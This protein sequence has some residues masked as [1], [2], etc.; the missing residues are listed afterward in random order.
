LVADDDHLVAAPGDSG[1]DVIDARA[2]CQAIVRLGWDVKRARELT[3][4]LSGAKERAREYGARPH[5]IGPELLSE[6]TGLLAALCRQ[7][8]Q[9]IGLSRRG[10]GVADEIEAHGARG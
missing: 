1:P 5:L 6:G 4:G 2:R 10:F 7:R 8:P 9:F 3:A